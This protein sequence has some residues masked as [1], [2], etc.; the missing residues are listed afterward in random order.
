MSTHFWS[1][2]PNVFGQLVQQTRSSA[3]DELMA[4]GAE[5]AVVLEE[6]VAV[7]VAVSAKISIRAAVERLLVLQVLVASP[8]PEI[9]GKFARLYPISIANIPLSDSIC[10]NHC[11]AA[12]QSMSSHRG[13]CSSIPRNG[14]FTIIATI[15]VFR[16]VGRTDRQ[17][18]LNS[19]RGVAS[20]CKLM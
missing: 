15:W 19:I 13:T 12:R 17:H 20:L 16:C 2:A 1:L 9:V 5:A 11:R 6:A 10:R 8:P 7:L 3:L 4:H 14:L 18:S